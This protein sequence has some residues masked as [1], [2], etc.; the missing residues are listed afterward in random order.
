MRKKAEEERREESV[1]RTSRD[2]VE[3]VE[4]VEGR[5]RM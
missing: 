2:V 4:K 3:G 5:E 1:S